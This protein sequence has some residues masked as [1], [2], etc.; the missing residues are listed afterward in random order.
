MMG[1]WVWEGLV[2]LSRMFSERQGNYTD[3]ERY[4]D[5]ARMKRKGKHRK[6]CQ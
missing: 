4:T 6:E 3:L 1:E 2:R 5:E